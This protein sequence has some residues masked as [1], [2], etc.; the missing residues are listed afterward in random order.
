MHTFFFLV[1]H[2]YLFH[3]YILDAGVI[4]AY[5]RCLPLVQLFGPTNFAPMINHVARFA[6]SHPSGDHYFIL[7][8]LTDGAICDMHDTK[9][10]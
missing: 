5:R 1:K 2:I 4:E 3:S 6:A 10:V 8:I 7:L 9:Q